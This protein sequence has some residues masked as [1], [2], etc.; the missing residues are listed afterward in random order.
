MCPRSFLP[1]S[2]GVQGRRSRKLPTSW[3]CPAYGGAHHQGLLPGQGSI[4]FLVE[5]IIKVFHQDRVPQRILEH[6]I[7]V[8]S[9]TAF[10]PQNECLDSLSKTLLFFRFPQRT[11][12]S[13]T[14]ETNT[15]NKVRLHRDCWWMCKLSRKRTEELIVDQRGLPPRCGLRSGFSLSHTWSS[16]VLCV[17][18]H[19]LLA[20]HVRDSRVRE[21]RHSNPISSWWVRT[22]S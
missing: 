1:S 16:I 9:L 17:V 21:M 3:R 20:P 10:S 2:R 22:L 4:A 7:K 18:P 8:C 19:G 14:T 11:V 15:M 12:H 6:I 13:Y 5:H